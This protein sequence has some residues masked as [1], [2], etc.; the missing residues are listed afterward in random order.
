LRWTWSWVAATLVACGGGGGQNVAGTD[1]G[2]G[3]SGFDGGVGDIRATAGPGRSDPEGI[4]PP[5]SSVTN[6]S[7][8]DSRGADRTAV[9]GGYLYQYDFT[10]A[11]GAPDPTLVTTRSANDDA[12]GHPG[13]GYVVSHNAANGNSPIGKANAPSRAQTTV[14][15]GGH[16][17]IHRVELVYDRDKEGG[18]NGIKIPV[19]I[20]WFVATGR[21]HPVWAVTWR[22]GAATNPGGV[23]FDAYRMDTRGPYGSLNWDGA[24]NR[25]AGDAIGGVAWG[26][27]GLR[28][29]TTDAQLILDSPWTYDTPNSVAF[30]QAW[31]ATVNAEMGIVQ[32]RPGDKSMGYPDRV[33]G[34]ER[35]NTS[36]G[37]YLDKRDCTGFGDNRTYSV[38]CVGGWPYQLMNF[39]WDPASGKPAREPT[40]TK[41]IAWGTPYG[42]LGAS[43][44]DLFDFSAMAD[45]RGDRS[46][47]TFVVA[48]PKCRYTAGGACDQPGDVALALAAVDAL[49][50]ATVTGVA[51]GS[52]VAQVPRGPGASDL[53]TIANGYDDTYGVYTLAAAGNQVAFTFTP[54]GGKPVKNP[55]FR[56]Q[57]FTAARLP[58]I[59]AG[60]A[61]VT[62]NTGASDSGAFVSVD[63]AANELWVTLNRTV[64]G[65]TAISI[66]A[67]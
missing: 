63:T 21:D 49:G 54:A 8:K 44:F 15:A 38:P 46:Y 7:W 37:N 62:I 24:P 20:D 61:P 64:T 40:S 4:A 11:G 19:V 52:L 25:G 43:A 6:L 14:L 9:L 58:T 26:D 13:F 35:D 55:I 59:A 32:T 3:G 53:K 48:G 17:A 47:A 5:S 45:G 27:F 10:F 60:S 42:W 66:A 51:P 33:L 30:T 16:H 22:M 36:G 12:F 2:T 57:G 50:S 31:T 65:A 67:P 29:T 23:D 18:G 34:R 56:I 28:F 1:A 41:L 39:D